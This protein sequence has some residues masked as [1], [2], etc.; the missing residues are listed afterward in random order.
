MRAGALVLKR[1][2]RAKIERLIV[3]E[4]LDGSARV[5][6]Q[7]PSISLGA[8]YHVYSSFFFYQR[9]ALYIHHDASRSP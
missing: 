3:D 2:L 9:R 8:V 7:T 6:P 5:T 1:S 4:T